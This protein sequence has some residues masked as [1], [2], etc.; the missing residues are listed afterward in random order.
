MTRD[1]MILCILYT[2][3]RA[4][5]RKIINILGLTKEN[6]MLIKNSALVKTG[7]REP[8]ESKLS[9]LRNFGNKP[10]HWIKNMK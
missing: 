1:S 9:G 6:T 3:Q 5:I 10:S 8:W 7:F 2:L 4:E